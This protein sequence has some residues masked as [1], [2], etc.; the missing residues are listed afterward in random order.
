[1]SPSFFLLDFLWCED[2]FFFEE[3][4]VVLE[5]FSALLEVLVLL[6]V[7]CFAAQDVKNAATVSRAMEDRTVLFIGF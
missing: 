1:V 2:D 6:A 5:A 3:V 7:S 4:S